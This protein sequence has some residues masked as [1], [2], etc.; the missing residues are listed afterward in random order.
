MSASAAL[1]R[2][3]MVTSSSLRTRSKY[4]RAM[5]EPTN[6]IG[7]VSGRTPTRDPY[8]ADRSTEPKCMA[9]WMRPTSPGAR[10]AMV[11]AEVAG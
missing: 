4:A 7:P 8:S 11:S 6:S 10:A 2:G 3:T 9:R 1:P 5:G